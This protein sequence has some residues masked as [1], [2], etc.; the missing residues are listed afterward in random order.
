[1]EMSEGAETNP[2]KISERMGK[3]MNV[4]TTEWMKWRVKVK[5]EWTGEQV[6]EWMNELLDKEWT[7]EW[8]SELWQ[9][10]NK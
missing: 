5:S 8:M 10:M 4:Q 2:N 9:W 3:Y 7:N 1:M 6:T